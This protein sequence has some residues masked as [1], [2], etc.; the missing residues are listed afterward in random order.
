MKPSFL[1]P[2]PALLQQPS[3]LLFV[4]CAAHAPFVFHA[5]IKAAAENAREGSL[6]GHGGHA[7]HYNVGGA[8]P[9]LIA[10]YEAV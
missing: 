1:S 7:R 9:A 8:H 4:A 6:L 10:C 5:S 2:Q 3:K